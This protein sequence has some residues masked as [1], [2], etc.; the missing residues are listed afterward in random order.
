M[1][2]KKRAPRLIVL[3]LVLAALP[4]ISSCDSFSGYGL[5]AGAP[6][7]WGGSAAGPPIFIGGPP[8]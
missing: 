2:Q 3:A 1:P 7:R 8:G 6:A 5:S 4:A